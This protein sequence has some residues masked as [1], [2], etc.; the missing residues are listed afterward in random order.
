MDW[1]KWLEQGFCE[2][3]VAKRILKQEESFNIDA[4]ARGL[5]ENEYILLNWKEQV[6]LGSLRAVE[7]DNFS[8][9]I[10]E[11]IGAVYVLCNVS[12]SLKL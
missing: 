2:Y 8:G 10:F 11:I 7:P 9:E 5:P 1:E 3:G 4:K 6:Y 12:R